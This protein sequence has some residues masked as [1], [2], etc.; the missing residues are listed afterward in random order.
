MRRIL[1]LMLVMCSL[2]T[3]QPSTANA[4]FFKKIFGKK[5]GYKERHDKVKYKYPAEE[6]ESEPKKESKKSKREKEEKGKRGTEER[7][8]SP[9]G[10]ATGTREKSACKKGCK[11]WRACQKK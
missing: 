11:G 2:F 6:K 5:S 4:Q 1:I 8:E 9:Q 3:V 7:E 10:Q